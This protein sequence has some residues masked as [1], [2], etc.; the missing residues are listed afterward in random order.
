MFL[1]EELLLV[2][3]CFGLDWSGALLLCSVFWLGL[4][5]VRLGFSLGWELVQSLDLVRFP[6]CI[7]LRLLCFVS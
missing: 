4:W 1:L 6:G 3:V 7:V 2:N 5:T